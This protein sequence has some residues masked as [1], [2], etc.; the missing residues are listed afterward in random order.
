[1]RKQKILFMLINMN[2]GGTEKA[3]LNMISQMPKN[4]YEITILML[5]KYGGF[6]DA[7]PSHVQIEYVENYKDIKTI[8]NQPPRIVARHLFQQ[9]KIIKGINLLLVYCISK[10]FKNKS[11]FFQ[12]VTK[13]IPK[14][15]SEYDIAVAYAGPM[16]FISFFVVHKINAKRRLQWIHFDVENFGIDKVFVERIYNKF[17]KVYVVSEEAKIKIIKAIPSIKDKTSVY[18]NIVSPEQVIKQSKI[19]SGFNDS[20]TGFKV[21]T[22]GRL[23]HEKGQDLAIKVLSRL[24]KKGFDIRWYCVGEGSARKE[25]ERLIRKYQLENHFILL[26]SESNPYPYMEQCDLYVQPSRHEGYCITLAE[27]KCFNK[28]IVTTNFSG[29]SEQIKHGETGLIINSDEQEMFTAVETILKDTKLQELF[30]QNL[31]L[32]NKHETIENSNVSHIL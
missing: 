31:M 26:G 17:E 18:L 19:G 7:I 12:Y 3:L 32:E 24:V 21:L 5:E 20:Y 29:A 11:Y 28:P 15:T 4:E 8:L 22:V 9:G 2:I 10:I 23:S 27:A 6:L 13:I 16:D 30:N 1:M 14:L 25:Y